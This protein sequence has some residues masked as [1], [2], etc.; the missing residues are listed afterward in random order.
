M[1][2]PVVGELGRGKSSAPITPNDTTELAPMRALY[3]GT[4]GTFV[5][6]LRNDSEDRTFV[7][8]DG[9]I[10]PFDFKLIKST[11]LTDAAAML[12]IR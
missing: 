1:W 11:G 2:G 8:A 6:R 7:V 12:A 3:V 10:L 4:G 9:A 5:G